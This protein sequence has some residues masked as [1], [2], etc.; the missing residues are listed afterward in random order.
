MQIFA[1][2]ARTA[3]N[4]ARA[5]IRVKVQTC[6]TVLWPAKVATIDEQNSLDLAFSTTFWLGLPYKRP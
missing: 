2:L 5:P 4:I 6:I 3:E 1:A